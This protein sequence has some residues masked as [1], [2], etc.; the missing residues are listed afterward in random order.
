MKSGSL[1]YI[2]VTSYSL[3]VPENIRLITQPAHS[4]ELNRVEH[5]WSEIR[6][7]HFYN[8]VFDSI[9]IVMDKLCQGLNELISAPAQLRSFDHFPHLR[10]VF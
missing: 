2:S 9:D 3:V 10:M 1:S 7:H 6:E 4:P 5:L 8:Q